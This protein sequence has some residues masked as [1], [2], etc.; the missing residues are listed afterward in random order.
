MKV[1]C[2]HL[3]NDF[4]GSPLV[5]STV[6]KGFRKKEIPVEVWTSSEGKGFLSDLPVDYK[7]I[8]YQFYQNKFLRLLAFGWAQLVLC[9]KLMQYKNQ[10]VVFYINTLLPFGAAIAGKILNKKVVY[11]VHETSVNPPILKSFLKWV[12]SKTASKAIYV[13][14]FLKNKEGIS[15]VKGVVVYNALSQQFVAHAQ[16]HIKREWHGFNV[17]MLCSLKAY[18]GVDEFVELSRSLPKYTF[19]LV[20][21][22]DLKNMEQYFSKTKLP[23]NLKLHPRQSNVHPFYQKAD[24][25]LNLS[26]PEKWI[27]TFGMTLLEAMQYGIPVIAPPVGGPTELVT[28]GYN[29]Y[30]I[31]Q[32]NLNLITSKITMLATDGELYSK[33]SYNSRDFANSFHTEKMQNQIISLLFQ[34]RIPSPIDVSLRQ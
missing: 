26:H 3:Y 33:L 14:H 10:D 11:H 24:L 19:E 6:I 16:G 21:N 27:E 32:R 8:P 7:S 5:L 2:I 23:S 20:V 13:S 31:D 9:I 30:Q 15:N 25:V 12:A 4:S 1:I 17:L 34:T 29:G 18:K 22:D 28:D